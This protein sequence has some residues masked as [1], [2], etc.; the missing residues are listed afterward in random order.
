[1]EF[2]A[3]HGVQLFD[4]AE[5]A[6]DCLPVIKII[7]VAHTVIHI[8]I[9]NKDNHNEKQETQMCNARIPDG[10]FYC[11]DV[12]RRMAMYMRELFDDKVLHF[13]REER[14]ST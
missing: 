11:H 12:A 5:T 1:M 6:G 2:A 9:N 14:A 10:H 3:G 13:V 7:G 4:F 8:W